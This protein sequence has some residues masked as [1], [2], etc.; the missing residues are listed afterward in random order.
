LRKKL[1]AKDY[2]YL[3]HNLIILDICK[4]HDLIT[5]VDMFITSQSF[6]I[7]ISLL[8]NQ[9][10]KGHSMSCLLGVGRLEPWN[11]EGDG[12][13]VWEAEYSTNNCVYM[14][15]NGKTK[16]VEIIPRMGREGGWLK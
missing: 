14:Y 12:K 4:P 8:Q 9:R 5:I 16:T 7:F 2:T 15:V 6:P 11:G 13:R 1:H 3:T 10:T